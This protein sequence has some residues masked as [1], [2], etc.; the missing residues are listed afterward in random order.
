MSQ[1]WRKITKELHSPAPQPEDHDRDLDP[2]FEEDPDI[3]V[4]LEDGVFYQASY[5][6]TE[7]AI[8][9]NYPGLLPASH[10][11]NQET[12][13]LKELPRS[14][15]PT[16]LSWA[17]KGRRLGRHATPEAT[18]KRAASTPGKPSKRKAN[19]GT[20]E[21]SSKRYGFVNMPLGSRIQL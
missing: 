2:G 13:P 6:G 16:A 8:T 12:S 1:E 9:A 5:D 15:S 18:P 7:V 3:F 17:Q 10:V 20:T 21:P 14:A 19:E 4:V 11:S